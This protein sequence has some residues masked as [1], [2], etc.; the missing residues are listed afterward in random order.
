MADLNPS[1]YNEEIN[2]SDIIDDALDEAQLA[3]MDA[4]LKAG[5]PIFGTC[6]GC[7]LINVY[8]GGSLVQDIPNHRLEK[9]ALHRVAIESGS[10]LE[11]LYGKETMVNSTHHQ[12]VGKFGRDLVPAAF[13]DDG[14]PEGFYHKE[15]P[16]F[17][18]QW[19]PERIMNL[20][21]RKIYQYFIELMQKQH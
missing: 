12:C 18:V 9:E 14:T 6:R 3:A 13:A 16:V 21:G 4:F 15:K 1:L 11:D 5:K 10:F 20:G 19:H 17:A 8:F 7:Q 2:G